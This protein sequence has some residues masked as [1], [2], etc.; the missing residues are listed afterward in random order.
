MPLRVG[1]HAH[2][3]LTG[4]V[5]REEVSVKQQTTECCGENCLKKALAVPLRGNLKNGGL[6][7]PE[8]WQIYLN[9]IFWNLRSSLAAEFLHLATIAY[10]LQNYRAICLYLAY[11]SIYPCTPRD[12]HTLEWDIKKS[13]CNFAHLVNIQS[14][15]T[16]SLIPILGSRD[17]K[18]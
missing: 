5:A 3:Q 1:A 6:D 12:F 2:A 4:V 11:F 10:C 15:A 8:L 14:C 9:F 7:S 16:Y 18:T 13:F 17:N